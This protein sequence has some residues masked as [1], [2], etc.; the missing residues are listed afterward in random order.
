MKSMKKFLG[1]AVIITVI[2]FM[3]LP[4][5]GCPEEEPAH[6]HVHKWGEWVET[7]ATD[8]TDGTKSR[9]CSNDEKHTE[10]LIVSSRKLTSV[11]ELTNWLDAVPDN[12]A[13]TAYKI[14][15][16]TNNNDISINSTL[17]SDANKNKY[18]DFDLSSST[19]TRFYNT[20][21]WN[22]TSLTSVTIP[23]SV[24]SIDNQAFL[25]CTN[26][27]SVTLPTNTSFI[28]IGFEIFRGC[29]SLTSV[30]IPNSV[31]TIGNLAFCDCSRLTS[32]TIPDSV[33]SIENSFYDCYGLTS[34][35]F[36]GTITSANFNNSAFGN[37]GDLRDKYLAEGGGIGTYTRSG[38]V[39]TKE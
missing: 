28:T 39:W 33:I 9:E 18:V 17:K 8:T 37:L 38:N 22:C 14:N 36:Q 29:T 5:T 4:L 25:N 2:G 10:T 23:N 20:V 3:T 13:D 11:E 6:A 15:F 21:F 35:T 1:I 27:T 19:I 30:T 7:P 34:V 31:T 12:T 32:V 16:S 24:T 26:L